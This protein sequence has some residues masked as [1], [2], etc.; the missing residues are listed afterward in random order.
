MVQANQT[1]LLGNKSFLTV[2]VE[3]SESLVPV[4]GGVK[5][6][7]SLYF[8]REYLGLD[9]AFMFPLLTGEGQG[10]V[11]SRVEKFKS[12]EEVKTNPSLFTPHSSRHCLEVYKFSS[13]GEVDVVEKLNSGKVEKELK[14]YSTFPQENDCPYRA[15][16]APCGRGQDFELSVAKLRNPGEGYFPSV[17]NQPALQFAKT[18]PSLLT[19]HSS[20]KFLITWSPD[21]LITLSTL[22]SPFT[23]HA[24]PRYHPPN[25]PHKGG[26]IAPF[27][28]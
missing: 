19:P 21:Y 2:G 10:E 24:S 3:R 22:P 7:C 27:P 25:L 6:A 15:P 4:G 13:L 8:R 16:L 26:K 17:H 20:L 9:E 1:E 14:I 5:Y 11:S 23:P 18:H 12:L 28:R